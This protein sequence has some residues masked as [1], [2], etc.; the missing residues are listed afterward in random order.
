MSDLL[1]I[2]NGSKHHDAKS[3]QPTTLYTENKT[4]NACEHC[5]H[6][7]VQE[8]CSVML[9]RLFEKSKL[10]YQSYF[11]YQAGAVAAIGN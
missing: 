5:P 7:H 1:R 9:N 10:K 8:Q 11:S 2:D 4:R 6:S 3:A